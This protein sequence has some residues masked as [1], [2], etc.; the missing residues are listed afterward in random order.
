MATAQLKI[1]K[2]YFSEETAELRDAVARKAA[3]L[4]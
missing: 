4:Q 1:P 2:R 3:F